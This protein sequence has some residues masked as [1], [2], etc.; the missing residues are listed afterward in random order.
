[1]LGTS[2]RNEPL[3]EEDGK[4]SARPATP[5]R[6]TAAKGEKGENVL[7]A[8]HNMGNIIWEVLNNVFVSYFMWSGRAVRY[9]PYRP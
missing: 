5:N 9:R 3:T 8:E 1:M 2:R 4:V 6:E 7:V